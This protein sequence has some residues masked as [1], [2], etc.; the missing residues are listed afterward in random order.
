MKSLVVSA[1]TLTWLAVSLSMANAS[2][3]GCPANLPAGTII[4]IFSNEKLTAG[5]TSGPIV[6]SVGSDVPFLPN[7]R[8]L[9][10]KGSKV[11]GQVVESE[12]AGRLWGKARAHI[13]L[14]SILTP[15]F[16]EY[17]IDAKI[18]EAGPFNVADNVVSG[19]GH[20][21]RDAFLLL[22]PPTTLYQVLRI[23]SR[24]PKLVLGTETPI[25]IKLMQPLYP[26]QALSSSTDNELSSLRAKIDQLERHI[27]NLEAAAGFKISVSP[28][29]GTGALVSAPCPAPAAVSPK[30]PI[31][32]KDTVL[33]PVRNSTPYHV[34]LYLNGAQVALL[35]PCYSSMVL[36]PTHAFRLESVASL[37]TT[38]GQ[39]Q[40]E[41][42]VV[43]NIDETGW[44]IV[45]DR[46]QPIPISGNR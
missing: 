22:F 12:Q 17:P 14:T 35:P 1:A 20:A 39:T 3:A 37:L 46:N 40:V 45:W 30:P 31:L 33:R 16:C 24:G 5:V 44:D 34:H 2:P 26:E 8:P 36:M 27:A 38:A 13:L 11:L 7:H 10:S 43:P 4:R 15:D 9:L 19:R 6:F 25:T 28:G 41:V 23:P 32:Y 29:E 18:V 21:K 42:K